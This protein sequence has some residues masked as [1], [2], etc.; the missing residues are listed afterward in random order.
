MVTNAKIEIFTEQSAVDA[1]VAT[2]ME[3]AHRG[4]AG[5]GIMAVLPVE[6]LYRI[7]GKAEA[8]PSDL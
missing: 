8:E 3:L 2:I 1:I 4:I 5:D 7:Q 6:K